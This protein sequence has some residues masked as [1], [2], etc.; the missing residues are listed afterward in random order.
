MD[1]A[2]PEITGLL[3]ELLADGKRVHLCAKGRSMRPFLSGGEILVVGPCDSSKIR[4]GDLLLCRYPRSRL[5][6]HRVVR[7]ERS[8]WR[9]PLF[10]LQGD[11]REEFDTPIGV[12]QVLGRVCVI[13]QN[14]PGDTIRSLDLMSWRW[15]TYA[16]TIVSI[17]L[18]RHYVRNMCCMLKHWLRPSPSI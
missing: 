3:E 13:E 18:A 11:A 14:G 6:I 4:L 1:L 2:D 15:R 17:Q 7:V 10:T 8:Q 9:A 5:L 16:Q 12:E